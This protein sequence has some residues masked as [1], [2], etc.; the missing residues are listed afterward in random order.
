MKKIFLFVMVFSFGLMVSCSSGTAAGCSNSACC[1]NKQ[2][3]TIFNILITMLKTIHAKTNMRFVVESVWANLAFPVKRDLMWHN[4]PT[5]WSGV[6]YRQYGF[7][8]SRKIRMH[9][10]NPNRR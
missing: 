2:T 4:H 8:I 1:K 5:P 10:K 6:Y 7:T 3:K 9:G